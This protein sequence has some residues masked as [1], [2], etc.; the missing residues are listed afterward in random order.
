MRHEAF[1]PPDWDMGHP[2]TLHIAL[3]GHITT[4]HGGTSRYEFVSTHGAT[5]MVD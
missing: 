4:E 3:C 1:D 5:I 2:P